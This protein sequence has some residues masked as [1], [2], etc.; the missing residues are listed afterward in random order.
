MYQNMY[1]EILCAQKQPINKWNFE[2]QKPGTVTLISKGYLFLKQSNS[3]KKAS[4]GAKK[5]LQM[6]ET[7]YLKRYRNPIIVIRFAI[8][9]HIYLPPRIVSLFLFLFFR[10]TVSHKTVCQWTN[11]FTNK[12]NLPIYKFTDDILI[13]HVDEKYVKVK[14]EWCYFRGIRLASN[15]RKNFD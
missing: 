7:G 9:L 1:H 15:R 12:I 8:L 6:A 3:P 2:R 4:W 11:K 5:V 10:A 14:G 13:Y